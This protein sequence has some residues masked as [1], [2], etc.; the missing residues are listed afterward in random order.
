MIMKIYFYVRIIKD[1]L[2]YIWL[3]RA[4]LYESIMK[5]SDKAFPYLKPTKSIRKKYSYIFDKKFSIP[6]KN[7]KLIFDKIIS[8]IFLIISFPIVVFLKAAFVIEGLIIPENKGLAAGA[9]L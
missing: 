2:I 3:I 5:I 9:E 8:V 4:I 7:L 6:K 1:K